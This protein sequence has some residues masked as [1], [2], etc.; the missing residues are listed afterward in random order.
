MSRTRRPPITE[1]PWYWVYVFSTAC[2][3]AIFLL[4][5]K[6]SARQAQIERNFQG[7]ERANELAGTGEAETEVTSTRDNTIIR[8]EPLQMLFA[9]A[10]VVAWCVIWWQRFR[11]QA[12]SEQKEGSP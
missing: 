10:I 9:A 4:G 11:P 3:V 2:L 5:P 7:R 6:Y 8:L 12:S 1:S